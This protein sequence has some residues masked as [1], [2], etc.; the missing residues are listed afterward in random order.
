MV[1]FMGAKGVFENVWSK[2][3]LQNGFAKLFGL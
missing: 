2:Y 3:N 1:L